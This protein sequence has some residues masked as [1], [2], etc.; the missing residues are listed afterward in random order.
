MTVKDRE[1]MVRLLTTVQRIAQG[2]LDCGRPL[3]A[4]TSRQIARDTLIELGETWHKTDR[5]R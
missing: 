5:A 4:E 2:R 3:S 1:W